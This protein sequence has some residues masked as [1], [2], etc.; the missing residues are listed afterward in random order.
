MSCGEKYEIGDKC[1]FLGYWKDFKS[2]FSVNMPINCQTKALDRVQKKE[3]KFANHTR[4]SARETLAQGRKVARICNLFKA[5]IGER[6]WQSIVDR[7]KGPCY[8]SRDDQDRQ[9]GP[10]NKEE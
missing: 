4:D 1:T 5:Y 3:A 7:L 6:T 10:G 9:I 8:L 2:L